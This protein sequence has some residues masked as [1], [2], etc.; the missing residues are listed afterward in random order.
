VSDGHDA[1]HGRA[2]VTAGFSYSFLR[3]AA[4]AT[5]KTSAFSRTPMLHAQP[6]VKVRHTTS[7]RLDSRVMRA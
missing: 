5:A 1:R 2:R 3:A 4:I 6:E 7:P